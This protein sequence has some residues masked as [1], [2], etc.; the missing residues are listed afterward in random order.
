MEFCRVEYVAFH[1]SC[2]QL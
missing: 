1:C 2:L